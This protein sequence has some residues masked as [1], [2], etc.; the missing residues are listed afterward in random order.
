MVKY[1]IEI[2]DQNNK[3]RKSELITTDVKNK[4]FKNIT[5]KNNDNNTFLTANLKKTTMHRIC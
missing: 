3:K 5:I 4:K 2:M 1:Y